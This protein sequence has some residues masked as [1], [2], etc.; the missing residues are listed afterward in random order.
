MQAKAK[1]KTTVT[2]ELTDNEGKEYKGRLLGLI[3]DNE[4]FKIMRSQR[5]QNKLFSYKTVPLSEIAEYA[6]L[7]GLRLVIAVK[8]INGTTTIGKHLF[9]TDNLSMVTQVQTE[10]QVGILTENDEYILV[11]EDG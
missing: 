9:I 8:E 4:F 10:G 6:D 5:I 11:T 3:N 7:K 2:L 1:K